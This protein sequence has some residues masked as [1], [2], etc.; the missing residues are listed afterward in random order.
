MIGMQYKVKLP[1]DYTMTTIR[2]RVKNNGDKMDGFEGL[3]FKVYLI[4]EKDKHGNHYN[5][6]APLYIWNQSEGLNH[7]LFEGFYDNII[8]SFGWQTVN[9]GIPLE[10]DLTSNFSNS[11]YVLECTGIIEEKPTLINV[12]QSLNN[13]D[14]LENSTSKVTIYNPD[15]WGYSIFYFFE[16]YPQEF[17]NNNDASIYEILHISKGT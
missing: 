9:I 11:N 7:F 5:A 13:L 15:K 6:Y 14:I 2:D 1:S 12:K 3:H 16:N 8:D 17:E 10:I 4:S